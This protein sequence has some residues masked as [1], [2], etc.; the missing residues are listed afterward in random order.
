MIV[1]TQRAFWVMKYRRGYLSLVG[2]Y[3]KSLDMLLP[4]TKF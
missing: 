2:S 4:A 3:A 1:L